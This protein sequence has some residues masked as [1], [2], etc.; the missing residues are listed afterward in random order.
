MRALVLSLVLLLTV[1]L[2][3]PSVAQEQR[4]E[5]RQGFALF[6]GDEDA[7]SAAFAYFGELGPSSAAA[8]ILA[9]RFVRDDRFPDVLRDITGETAPQSWSDWMLW[10]EAHPEIEPFE[11]FDLLHAWA[12]SQIDAN[13]QLFLG[14]GKKHEIRI[15]EIVWG[16]VIKDGIPALN[17]PRLIAAGA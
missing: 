11:G 3:A 2:A 5:V 12:H 15:E 6:T 8:L 4:E 17:H 16:G 14:A 10:Q 13:F 9:M 7:R 1:A